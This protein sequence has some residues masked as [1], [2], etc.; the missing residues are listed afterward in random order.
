MPS[1]LSLEAIKTAATQLGVQEDPPHANKGVKVNAYLASVGLAPGYSWC[2]AFG[3]WCFDQAATKL[4]IPNPLVK[5]GGVLNHWNLS[6]A[7]KVTVPQAGDI[8]IIDHGKGLG[9]EVLVRSVDI[10]KGTYQS[11]EGNSNEN[12]SR[13]GF[14]VCSNTRQIKA[15]KGFLRY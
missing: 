10:P 11:I 9:H 15:A 5:T 1:I 14:I 6:K 3:Y 13:E 4:N 8:G 12:G 7:T 2:A